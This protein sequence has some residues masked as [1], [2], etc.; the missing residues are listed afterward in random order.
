MF[1]KIKL[2]LIQEMFSFTLRRRE[3]GT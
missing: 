3:P 1:Q 2:F